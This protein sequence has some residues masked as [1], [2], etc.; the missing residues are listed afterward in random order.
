MELSFLDRNFSSNLKFLILVSGIVFSH[1]F[2]DRGYSYPTPVDYDGSVLRWNLGSTD[3]SITYQVVEEEGSDSK[4][5]ATLVDQAAILWSSVDTSSIGLKPYSLEADGQRA[6]ISIHLAR[7]IDS[8]SV[9]SGYAIFDE[10]SES[11]PLHCS[12][13]VLIDPLFSS[14]A[15]GKTILH[16]MGHCLGLGHSLIPEAI[17]SYQLEKNSFALDLDDKAA[18][19]RLYPQNGGQ[20]RLPI[21]CAIGGNQSASRKSENKGFWIMAL[22]LGIGLSRLASIYHRRQK[23]RS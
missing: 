19:S 5:Y 9:S 14:R 13:Y 6:M 15:I 22:P 21:G 11:G 18:L 16:E 17:M 23:V 8:S 3:S 1:V 2:S 4:N 20:P 7:H 12:V 10:Y